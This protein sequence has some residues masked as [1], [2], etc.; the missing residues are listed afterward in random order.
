MVFYEKRKMIEVHLLCKEKLEESREKRG[1]RLLGKDKH[2]KVYNN[3]KEFMRK[4]GMYPD[5]W[6][7]EHE[8]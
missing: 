5:L 3:G 8:E 2:V 7:F 4:V 1:K 6:S